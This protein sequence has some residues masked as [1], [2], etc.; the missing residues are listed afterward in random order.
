MYNKLINQTFFYEKK[1]LINIFLS[2]FRTDTTSQYWMGA[3]KETDS[4]GNSV[5]KWATSREEIAV[6]FWNI[7]GS[8]GN[9]ARYDGTGG[10]LWSETPCNA[11]INYICQHR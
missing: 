4:D 2:L 3:V 9:C 6:S 8:N 5:W 11:R 1:I 10:W 7:P